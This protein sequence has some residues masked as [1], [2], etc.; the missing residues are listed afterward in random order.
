MAAY[1]VGYITIKDASQWGIYMKGVR[2]SLLSYS[3]EGIFR[4]LTRRPC[5]NGISQKSTRI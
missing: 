5:R 2:K 3:A 4:G 1:L